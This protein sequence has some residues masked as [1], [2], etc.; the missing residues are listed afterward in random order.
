MAFIFGLRLIFSE[1]FHLIFR[2][3]VG[4]SVFS[5]ARRL[6]GLGVDRKERECGAEAC[7]DSHYGGQW[8]GIRQFGNYIPP[9]PPATYNTNNILAREII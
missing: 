8:K 9:P 7:G 5:S 3:V 4:C 1:E 6:L 2:S